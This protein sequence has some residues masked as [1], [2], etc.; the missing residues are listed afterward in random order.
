MCHLLS[1]WHCVSCGCSCHC[2][3]YH[4]RGCLGSHCSFS[5]SFESVAKS[6][7]LRQVL[8]QGDLGHYAPLEVPP[9]LP[10]HRSTRALHV[11]RA[12]MLH[13]AWCIMRDTCRAMQ[14][15]RS[16]SA[17]QTCILAFLHRRVVL[18]VFLADAASV[19]FQFL[20]VEATL[21]L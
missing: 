14:A 9:F 19:P 7:S 17:P 13:D 20:V 2:S 10:S 18:V 1:P 21:T 8:R 15:S 16:S 5:S 6:F 11:I 4:C 3:K 12:G